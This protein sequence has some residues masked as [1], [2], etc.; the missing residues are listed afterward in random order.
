METETKPFWKSPWAIALI[1]IALLLCCCLVILGVGAYGLYQFS[2]QLPPEITAPIIEDFITPTP[3][4]VTRVPVENVP[5]DTLQTL[6]N[7]LVPVNDP[8][9]LAKRLG[10]KA[11]VPETL[12]SG[13]FSVGAK[14]EFWASNV[15]TNEN[16][17]VNAT[18][19]Y[20]TAHSYFWVQDGVS[21]KESEL[22]ALA[23]AF[24]NKIYPTD[25]EF[26]GS[27]WT[28][29][30]DGDP[31]IYI[32]YARGLGGN[33]AGY[34][35]SA[36]ELHPLAH[37]YS[38]AHEMFVFNADNTSFGEQYT[39]GV[40]A[41]EFQHMIHWYQDR[42]ETSWLNEGASELAAFLNGYDVGGFDWLFTSNPDL[43]LTDWPNDPSATS[44]HY[45]A[46][47][48]F[49]NYFLNRFGD[50]ATQALVRHPQNGMDSVNAVLSEIQAND[51]L[52]GQP[53]SA[54]QFFADWTVAN[55]LNDASVS[56][57]RYAYAN[58]SALKTASETDTISSCPGDLNGR[59]VNQYGADYIRITCAGNY[60]LRFEG[61]SQT[62]LLPADAHSG[63]YAF[64]SNKGDESDMTLTREF[65]LSSVSGAANLSYW[66]WYDLEKDYDYLYLAAS[67]DGGATWQI[68]KTPSGTDK[69]VSGNSY[70][71]GYN[72]ESGGWKQETV[73]LSAF[74]GQKVTLRFEYVTDA[75]VNGE[76]FLLD[77]ISLPEAGY[78]A[79][80]ET[81]DGG[82]QA[83]GFARV[84]NILP[85]KFSVT[86]IRRGA[87]T[88]VETL[89]VPADG[90]LEIPLSLGG[91]VNEVTVV[92]SGLT[93]FTREKGAYNL[94]VR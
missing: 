66:V 31:H 42:N 41:H 40:L 64:W 88:S 37:E 60:T 83:Q 20:E 11:N 76:G 51:P 28:P 52:S 5:V 24:E 22:R 30:V 79:D 15:D 21:Y 78:S 81:D 35:S 69:D 49:T 73:D 39:Y 77:D 47:F 10:G 46:G 61:A 59:T 2:Q 16:F 71:W 75:A 65:D 48:L 43:Q 23:D 14:Q 25:R 86:L 3:A 8:V 17:K 84:E 45:G 58:Y 26:F 19:R 67:T 85:Q 63:R 93:P 1:V 4:P 7:A 92:I 36:D 56:D 87:A 44:A 29:G 18:L 89:P 12:P 53:I 38:N 13:P 55:Y 80:F 74:A 34:F 57:G 70:G 68:V 62:K 90:L 54:D 9:D 94:S 32:L 33:L 72:G 82:W 27:E 50:K 91:E 6:E